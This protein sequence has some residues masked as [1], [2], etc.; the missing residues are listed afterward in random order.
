MRRRAIDLHIDELVLH[1]FNPADRH[2]I[3]EAVRSEL[4]RLLTERGIR[5]TVS[6]TRPFVSADNVTLARNTPA[7]AVGRNVARALFGVLKR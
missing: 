4:A 5:R 1:G 3:G 6:V 2:R 7:R